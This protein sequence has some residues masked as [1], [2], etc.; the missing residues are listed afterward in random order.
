MAWRRLFKYVDRD[1]KKRLLDLLKKHDKKAADMFIVVFYTIGSIQNKYQQRPGD[2]KHNGDYGRRWRRAFDRML[3]ASQEEFIKSGIFPI[4]ADPTR[5]DAAV[6]KKTMK[7]LQPRF[8]S[9]QANL[10]LDDLCKEFDPI[11]MEEIQ[12]LSL[13]GKNIMTIAPIHFAEIRVSGGSAQELFW[14]EAFGVP[15]YLYC[16]EEILKKYPSR[17]VITSIKSIGKH[18]IRGRNIFHTAED[19]L[20]KIKE[21]LPR[22]RKEKGFTP[23]GKTLFSLFQLKSK[24]FKKVKDNPRK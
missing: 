9:L 15:V 13:R 8:R 10:K 23:L 7:V 17:H 2:K 5:L 24:L 22:L 21:D 1:R 4:H 3:E 18:V 14:A 16:S 19:M 12:V 20:N 11:K 6:S